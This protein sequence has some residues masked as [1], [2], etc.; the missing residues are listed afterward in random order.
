M[1]LNIVLGKPKTGKSSYIYEKIKE[2]LSNDKPDK[3]II[4]KY[5]FCSITIKARN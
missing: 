1:S 5:S 3:T 2:E 4:N